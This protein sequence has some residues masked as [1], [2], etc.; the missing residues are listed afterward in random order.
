MKAPVA[1]KIAKELTMHGHTRVDNYY[2]MNERGTE[3]V[4]DYLNAENTYAEHILSDTK[5]LQDKLFNE[6]V[7]R[8]KQT[9]MS[10]PYKDNGYYY[11]TRYEEGKEYPVF[12]RKKESLE[13]PE[14]IV[15]NVNEMAEGYSYYNVAGYSVSPDNKVVAFGVDTLSRRIYTVYFKN[16]E[17]NEILEEKIENTT[18]RATWAGDNKTVFFSV[19]DE[20]TL[21]PYRVFRYTLGEEKEAEKVFQEDDEA[22]HSFVY[23]SRSKKYIIIGSSSTV[24][25]EYR[26]LKADNP[27]GG[28]KIVQAR[29]RGL[30]YSIA[31]FENKFYIKTNLDA[32]NFRLMEVN[33]EQTAKE[34]WKEVIPHR[35]DVFLEGFTAFA[36]Y[37]VLEERIKGVNQLRIIQQRDKKEHYISFG[38]DA[39]TAWMSVNPEFNTG[40]LRLGYSSL[41]TPISTYD[42]NMATREM[43]LLKRQEVVGGYEPDEY[44]SERLYAKARDG[45]E[46]PVSLVYK[47]GTKPDGSAPLLLYAYGSYGS[48]VDP[49][50]SSTR[51]SL[52]NRGFVF[53]IAHIRGGQVMGRQWYEDGKMLKK[54]NTF[55]DYV[56]CAKHLLDK[57]YTSEDRLFAMGGSAGGLLMG[58]I[59]NTNPELFKGVVAAVPFVD[60]VTT[61]LDE[62]IPLTTGEF[63]EWGNPKDKEYYDYMLSYSPYDNVEGKNYPNLLVTSGYHDSQVQYWEPAKWVA[64]LRE[65]KT[66]DN[67]LLLYTNMEAGHGGASGR[68]RRYRETAM[69]YAFIF[70]L[71]GIKE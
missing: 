56:D 18:G 26:I 5:E 25:D 47:K 34:N 55:N 8:I 63:D 29:E 43:E 53:A 65:M 19:K 12:C 69:E 9:D 58:V 37:L 62:S 49:Y 32:Q 6:I 67:I 41:T 24:S 59:I 52:L 22:F 11:Y 13:S 10:V 31:H 50:F 36:D 64:K 15:L 44:Q 14:E 28:F 38:E 33:E 16:L 71:T 48:T 35:K 30:E 68:F 46:V 66:D 23:K 1:K 4:E 60:V 17:T 3:D 27:K 57:K 21:R 54:K 40:T 7:G 39:F 2:W 42:Y 45:V 61:M 70:K 20:E 51:L